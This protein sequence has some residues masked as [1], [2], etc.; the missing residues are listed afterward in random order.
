M[1]LH[2]KYDMYNIVFLFCVLYYRNELIIY[3]LILLYNQIVY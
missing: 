1:Y 2:N 3:R